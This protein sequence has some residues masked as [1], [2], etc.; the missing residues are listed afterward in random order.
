MLI[1]HDTGE[2]YGNWVIFE[3]LDPNT[4]VWYP[5]VSIFAQADFSRPFPLWISDPKEPNGPS[6][7]HE[8]VDFLP[9]ESGSGVLVRHLAGFTL[10]WICKDILYTL[11]VEHLPNLDPES[12][13][14][15][16]VLIG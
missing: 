15:L 9:N 11:T 10:H 12:A 6:V 14:D 2:V 16:L 1:K 13:A 3:A 5:A 4:K 8:K 7:V